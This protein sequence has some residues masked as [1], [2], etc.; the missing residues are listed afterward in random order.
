MVGQVEELARRSRAVGM[1]RD[2]VLVVEDE[3]DWIDNYRDHLGRHELGAVR[4]ARTLE[5]ALR[6]IE[7]MQFSVA[8]VDVG[9][10][11]DDD[12]NVD[13]LRVMEKI[14]R[15]GDETSVVVVT[16][17]S[18]R[19]VLP[20]VRDAIKK[21]GALDTVSKSSVGPAEIVT[22]LKD[23]LEQFRRATGARRAE[24]IL[25][26]DVPGWQWD[27]EMLR[28][29]RI[30]GGAGALDGALALTSLTLVL[31]RRVDVVGSA[32]GV[33]AVWA[34]AVVSSQVRVGELAAFGAT[35][36]LAWLAVAVVSVVVLV[37]DRDRYATRLGGV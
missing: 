22:L 2:N 12:R 25:R 10:D 26:G 5:E 19:D 15:C 24:Q 6:G 30:K 16:G 4:V 37:A 34:V 9:L 18:G 17:R 32:V 35:R 28:R 7:E 36:Q 27:H 23:G 8:F 33:A 11:V 14:R 31:A 20:I 3:E 29:T 1:T 21:Y 13:G